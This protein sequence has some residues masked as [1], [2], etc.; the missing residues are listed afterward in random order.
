MLQRNSNVQYIQKPDYRKTI[1]HQKQHHMQ[2]EKSGLSYI[3][4]KVRSAV[5]QRDGECPAPQD[6]W[7]PLRHRDEEDG[8]ASHGPLLPTGPHHGGSRSEGDREDSQE[9]QTVEK[10][11]RM[12]LDLHFQNTVS[13]QTESGW[14]TSQCT[15]PWGTPSWHTPLLRRPVPLTLPN[16]VCQ[17]C[18]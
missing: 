3:M 7:I 17:F 12:L 2:D 16:L 5:Y 11:K 18:I 6:G 10:G 14:M 15:P 1:Q 8:K 4:Q 13:T 9:Q